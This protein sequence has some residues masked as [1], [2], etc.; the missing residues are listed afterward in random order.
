MKI[1]VLDGYAA[2]PGDLSWDELKKS[3]E[4]T[5][6][7]RTSAEE[8]AGR[9]DDAEYILTNKTV[10]S[11]ET[12]EKCEKLKYVGVLATGFNIVDTKAA[13]E[14]GI[15]V[16]N[17]PAYSTASVA[18]LATALLLEAVSRPGSHDIAVKN[19]E[20][21]S[22]KDFCFWKHP[23]IELEGKT[24]GLIGYGQT[25]KAFGDVA[26]ALGMNVLVYNRTKEN[27]A[28]LPKLRYAGLNTVFSSSDIISLH[29]PLNDE[30]RGIINKKSIAA[31]KDGVIIIN[32]ARGQL[33]VDEDL[34]EALNSGK[35]YCAALDVMTTEPPKPDNPL[36]SAKNT[37]ITPHMAWAH[38][39]ARQRL[40]K[41][42]CENV[43][44]H[45]A[46]RPKNIVNP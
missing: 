26:L 38:F 10:L 43:A 13:R 24:L 4:L 8:L 7:E 31:M 35:V 46:G 40:M 9:I 19:G 14:L 32:T 11:R 39:E 15:D 29:V 5:V 22:C 17:V 27:V 3:G 44:E 1:V 42:A 20:W 37:V 33:I 25:G 21:T 16:T 6:Y 18:Q 30:T 36:L 23:L 12:L 28:E 2:N 41:T 45:M 34:A